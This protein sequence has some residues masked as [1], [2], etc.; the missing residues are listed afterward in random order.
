MDGTPKPTRL[1]DGDDL[2][3]F[4]ERHDVALVEFYTSG[5]SKCQAMEPVLGNVAR[6]TGISVGLVNPGDDIPLV[7]RF[8]IDSVPT[9][10][11]F[12]DGDE[13]VRVADGFVGGDELVAVLETHVPNAV[14][15]D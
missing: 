3:A 7:D 8:D 1:A 5:C 6:A 12:E 13:R 9:L 11:L 4:L 2:D 15:R 14:D 10:L